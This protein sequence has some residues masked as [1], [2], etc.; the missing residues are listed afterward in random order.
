MDMEKI[1]AISPLDGRYAAKLDGLRR[2]VSEYGLIY[3]RT[4]TEIRW[5]E[6]LSTIK[7]LRDR[8]KLSDA[9]KMLLQHILDNFSIDDAKKVKQLEGNMNHDVKAVEYFLQEKLSVNENLKNAIPF[10]H[11]A[12]TSEDINN[13]AYSL[14]LKQTR[15]EVILPALNNIV[16]QL[17]TMV[18]DYADVPM[19]SRTHGQVASPTTVG[20]ELANVMARLITN[21]YSFT[22]QPLS[23]KINGA[24]GNFNAHLVAFPEANWLDISRIFIEAL[25]LTWNPYTTQIEPHDNLAALLQ[26]VV[27]INTI[28][29]D[30]AQ[31]IWG[32]VSLNYFQQKVLEKEVGSSTMPHKVNP[33]DFENAEGNLGVANAL[34]NHLINKLPI[35]RFQRDLSDS[36]VLRNLGSVF[37]YSLVAYQSLSKGL[38]KLTI[39]S[40]VI[41]ADLDQHWEILGEAVQ[42]VM[43]AQGITDAYEQ[44]KAFTRGHAI[45][46]EL[47]HQFIHQTGLDDEA[48][49]RLLKLTP[50]SYTGLASALAKRIG[51]K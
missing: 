22:Q 32:Y 12:C 14:I 43:R 13:V 24:V 41:A 4:L 10:I 34:A 38:S 45:N 19:L 25:G 3:F 6:I 20:K 50:A 39:N 17:Q 49:E 1:T 26:H 28:L 35:S 27:R 47:L 37:G 9:D 46:R 30:L 42:T 8:F 23:A 44:L 16:E 48:K 15:H 40:A 21:I 11:F 31:D 18:Q 36:T 33:I 7:G 5:L 29:I 51:D 2:L